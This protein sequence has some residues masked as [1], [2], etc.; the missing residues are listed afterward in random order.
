MSNIYEELK[1]DTLAVIEQVAR[2]HNFWVGR[3]SELTVASNP[4]ELAEQC[5]IF[6]I[7]DAATDKL[8]DILTKLNALKAY[9]SNKLLI[10]GFETLGVPAQFVGN[11]EYVSAV[12]ITGSFTDKA[13]GFDWLREIG[14]EGMIVETVHSQTLS[15]FIKRY[16]EEEVKT[17]PEFVKVNVMPYVKIKE[18]KS[19]KNS[20][21]KKSDTSSTMVRETTRKPVRVSRTV[22]RRKAIGSVG[23]TQEVSV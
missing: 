12:R 14:E 9:Y 1:A 15:A 6:E 21:R 16:V 11:K 3:T 13:A 7:L 10:K 23:Q 17:P 2:T 20:T 19:A 8:D 5:T 18:V 4:N 22:S